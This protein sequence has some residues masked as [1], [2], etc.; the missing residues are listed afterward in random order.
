MAGK[1]PH[2]GHDL[3]PFAKRC[4][5]CGHDFEEDAK[6]FDGTGLSGCISLIGGLLLGGAVLCFISSK[7]PLSIV[8]LV[9]TI[10]CFILSVKN[11]NS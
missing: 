9:L 6:R 4:Y 7:F 5:N 8:L 11:R 1:C 3:S 2:C 10:L